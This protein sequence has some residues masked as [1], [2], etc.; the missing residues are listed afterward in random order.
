VPPRRL[1]MDAQL[2]KIYQVYSEEPDPLRKNI[3]LSDLQNR[4]ETLFFRLLID[5]IKELGTSV[6]RGVV[7]L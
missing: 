4:N 1:D 5:N 3:F 6:A 2:K 7:C